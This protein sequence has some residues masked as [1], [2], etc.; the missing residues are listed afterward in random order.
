MSP[1]PDLRL[2]ALRIRAAD[3]AAAAISAHGAHVLSWTPRQGGERLYLSGR[4]ESGAGKAIRGG[5]PVIFPQFAGEGALPKHGFA[6]SRAWTALGTATRADG[7]AEARFALH[8]DA[9]TRAIWPQAFAAELAVAVLG[10][11]LDVTL[12]VRNTGAEP[13][14]FT[15]ALHTYLRVADVERARLTGLQGLRYRDSAQGNALRTEEAERLAIAGE[16][17]R[18]Y[19]DARA[20]LTLDDGGRRLRVAHSGFADVVVWN[21]GAEKAAALADLDD[22]GWREMLCVEAAVVG[23]PV[24][25]EPG[26]GWRGTQTLEAT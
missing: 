21:P 12:A 11:R 19:F 5:V 14:A 26:A 22:G 10:E 8:D 16:V 6:R 25:L 9:S 24:E 17:D 4:A 7:A 18:I 13:F 20:P 15:A 23:R 2:P 1:P 3:G